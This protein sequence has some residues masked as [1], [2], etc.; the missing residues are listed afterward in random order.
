MLILRFFF[1]YIA[2]DDIFKEQNKKEK[3]MNKN[4]INSTSLQTAYTI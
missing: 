4:E 3:K 1:F 2:I